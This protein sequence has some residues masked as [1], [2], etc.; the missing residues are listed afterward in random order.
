MGLATSKDK[1]QQEGGASKSDGGAKKEVE[2]ERILDKFQLGPAKAN[3][4]DVTRVRIQITDDQ[5]DA[6]D[7]AVDD[8]DSDGGHKSE[9]GSYLAP[10]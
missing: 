2:V 1:I 7:E 8:G 10:A 4:V 6:Q 9:E 5:Y 3:T